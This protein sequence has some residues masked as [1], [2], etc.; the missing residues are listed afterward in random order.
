V[1]IYLYTVVIDFFYG[2][3]GQIDFFR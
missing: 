3:D 1:S 2:G